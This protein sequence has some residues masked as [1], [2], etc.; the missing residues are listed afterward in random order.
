MHFRSVRA[1]SGTTSLARGGGP[2]VQKGPLSGKCV[3]A[4]SLLVYSSFKVSRPK[5]DG[6]HH[7]K[8]VQ[9]GG[10]VVVSPGAEQLGRWGSTVPSYRTAISAE[11]K[12]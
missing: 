3:S 9:I 8:H 10:P 1:S 11:S 7:S 5:G 2:G 4:Y 12:R 6:Q